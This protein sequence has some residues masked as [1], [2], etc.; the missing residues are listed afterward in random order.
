MNTS[1]HNHTHTT[2]GH[3]LDYN[4][5]FFLGIILNAVYII[6]ELIYGLSVRSMALVADAGHNFSDVLGLVLAWGA[7]YLAGIRISKTKTYGLKKSTVLAALFNAIILLIAVGA[8]TIEAVRKIW[9]PQPIAGETVMIVAGIGVLIN[10]VTALLFL[11][12]RQNDINIRGAFLH[13]AADAGVSLGVVVTGLVIDLTGWY[14]LDPIISLII[15]GIITFGTWG[16]MRDAFLM[17]M[18]AVPK[19]IDFDQVLSYLKSLNDVHDVHD[20]HIWPMSTTETALT[21]HIV[22]D[23]M[24]DTNKLIRQVEHHLGEVFKIGHITVQ[25]ETGPGIDC[26]NCN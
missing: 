14:P 19:N 24:T 16:L 17:S 5:V 2:S 18:D 7:S 3:T 10:T 26:E 25:I 11:K 8:I 12:G 15:A 21:V 20:L 23:E 22:V 4:R 9:D 1:A 6:I 13:M